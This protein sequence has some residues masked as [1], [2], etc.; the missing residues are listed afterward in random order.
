MSNITNQNRRATDH[1]R[2]ERLA[3]NVYIRLIHQFG[4]IIVTAIMPLLIW[5]FE[6]VATD[7]K[8]SMTNNTLAIF[9]IKTMLT[10][11]TAAYDQHFIDV[12]RRITVIETKYQH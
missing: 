8:N 3:D 12:D 7:F 11:K 4:V 9:D 6:G 2:S 10:G 1:S 5:H